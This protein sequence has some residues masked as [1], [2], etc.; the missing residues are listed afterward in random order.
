MSNE[1]A[2]KIVQKLKD[3]QNGSS[4]SFTLTDQ[5]RAV[6]EKVLKRIS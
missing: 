1:S 6:L 3:I 4:D 5:E 2:V